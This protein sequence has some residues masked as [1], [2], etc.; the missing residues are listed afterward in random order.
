MEQNDKMH[1]TRVRAGRRTYFLDVKRGKDGGHYIV[2]TES[3]KKG[4]GDNVTFEKTKIFLYPEDVNKFERA[5]K[6]SIVKLKELMPNYDFDQYT[7][8]PE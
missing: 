2:L 3:R 4:V 6:E 7:T 5:L 8:G 1:M